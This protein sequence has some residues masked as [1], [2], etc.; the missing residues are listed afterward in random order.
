[1]GLSGRTCS[2][3]YRRVSKRFEETTTGGDGLPEL[4]SALPCS[5]PPA[6]PSGQPSRSFRTIS[7]HGQDNVAP[8]GM[9][10][11]ADMG[12]AGSRG[13]STVLL[14][15]VSR[16]GLLGF[17]AGTAISSPATT[18]SAAGADAAG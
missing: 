5:P 1:M 9:M 3:C 10:T 17:P 11:G 15:R 14:L 2:N 12:G 4:R 8:A 16:C 6:R 7:G 13:A 18:T